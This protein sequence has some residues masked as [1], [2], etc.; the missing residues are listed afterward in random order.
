MKKVVSN[1][2]LWTE[3]SQM[4][5]LPTASAVVGDISQPNTVHCT[6]YNV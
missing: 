3:L 6:L 4:P 5:P 2:V 1:S